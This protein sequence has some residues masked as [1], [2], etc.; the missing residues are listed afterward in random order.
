MLFGCDWNPQLWTEWGWISSEWLWC[1]FCR[2][3]G[4]YRPKTWFSSSFSLKPIL[5]TV[6]IS[7]ESVLCQGTILDSN[8]FNL[9]ALGKSWQITIIIPFDYLANHY[10]WNLV[11]T[12]SWELLR[13]TANHYNLNKPS[14]AIIITW[15]IYENN[16][17]NR[18]STI[19]RTMS[20]LTFIYSEVPWGRSCD[21]RT[22]RKSGSRNSYPR[23]N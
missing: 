4:L 18:N 16:I 23:V 12:L 15:K 10:R 13:I 17:P 19:L 14:Y 11:R 7:I 21:R 3:H 1:F 5:P 20:L 2:K 22:T 6:Y 8:G 9:K